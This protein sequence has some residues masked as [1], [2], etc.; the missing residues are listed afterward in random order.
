MRSSAPCTNAPRELTPEGPVDR[1]ICTTG[2]TVAGPQRGYWYSLQ[3]SEIPES[4]D[5]TGSRHA[6]VAKQSIYE[7]KLEKAHSVVFRDGAVTK[8]LPYLL[9]RVQF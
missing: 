5:A 9:E 1:I 6:K 8:P 7:P 2:R 4:P 3:R